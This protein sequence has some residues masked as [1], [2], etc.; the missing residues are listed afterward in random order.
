[1]RLRNFAV[2]ISLVFACT[3]AAAVRGQEICKGD[4]IFSA[5]NCAGDLVSADEKVL[6]EAVNKYRVANGRPAVKLSTALS[7][8]G[9][10]RMLDLN[11]NLKILTHSWSNCPYDIYNEKTWGCLIGSPQRLNSGYAGEGY[12]T[13][14]RTTRSKVDVNAA[15]EAWKKSSLH[16]SIILNHGM[17]A[18]LPWDEFGVAIDGSYAALWFGFQKSIPR[19]AQSVGLGIS[20]DQAITGLAR[21]LSIEQTS[22]TGEKNLWQGFSADKRLKLEIR[23]TKKEISEA[24]I[25]VTV[26]LAGGRLDPAKKA[27]M[28]MLLKNL[29]PDWTDIDTWLDNSLNLIAQNRTAWRTKIIRKIAVELKSETADSIILS[30]K[31]PTRPAAMEIF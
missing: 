31:P 29:F 1:M 2:F 18:A 25:G 6:F 22:S 7:L 17:F 8:V 14:F 16:N 9:N 26:R 20:Y 21:L 30:V 13:L 12:E 15:L 27:V 23:G 10:R 24:N 11:Q 5:K 3:F 19:V 28:S 4:R